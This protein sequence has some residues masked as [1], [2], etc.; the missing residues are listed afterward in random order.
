MNTEK[1]SDNIKK[2]ERKKFFY[3]LGLGVIGF[4]T[5]KS[6]LFN[7]FS[8]KKTKI[9]KTNVVKNSRVKINPLAVSRNKTGV[10]NG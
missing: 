5:T 2:I 7:M 10:N 1:K 6:I 4:L 8:S 3:S 9:N